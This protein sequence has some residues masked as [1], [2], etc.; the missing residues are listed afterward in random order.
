MPEKSRLDLASLEYVEIRQQLRN[1]IATKTPYWEN[2]HESD[3]LVVMVDEVASLVDMFHFYLE[4]RTNEMILSRAK[5]KQ[6]VIDLSKVWDF[7]LP[8]PFT[9]VYEVWIR[10]NAQKPPN[11]SFIQTIPEGTRFNSYRKSYFT[12][13]SKTADFSLSSSFLVYEGFFYQEVFTLPILDRGQRVVAV[14]LLY[15]S[16][17]QNFLK[18]EINGE[19]WEEENFSPSVIFNPKKYLVETDEEGY[20]TLVFNGYKYSVPQDYEGNPNPVVNVSYVS[21]TGVEGKL[22]DPSEISSYDLSSFSTVDFSPFFKIEVEKTELISDYFPE[23]DWREAKNKV[24]SMFSTLWRAVSLHDY[25]KLCLTL[26]EVHSV[27]ATRKETTD[28]SDHTAQVW[29][30]R[31]DNT[32]QD[33]DFLEE[34][35]QFLAVRSCVGVSVEAAFAQLKTIYLALDIKILSRDSTSAV[36]SDVA[37]IIQS[38]VNSLGVGETLTVDRLYDLVSTLDEVVSVQVNRM[39][40]VQDTKISHLEPSSNQILSLQDPASLYISVSTVGSYP[41]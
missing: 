36:K 2:P 5:R 13:E 39:S 3:P 18:V 31:Y 23:M 22:N 12:R 24:S 28:K 10:S 20:S 4:Q 16:I 41:V 35:R 26:P 17:S 38:L 14:P 8:R 6:S 32:I 1:L 11:V 29:L 37:K 40:F 19:V 33:L 34:T 27:K 7:H 21:T 15:P 25:E 30:K 9:T